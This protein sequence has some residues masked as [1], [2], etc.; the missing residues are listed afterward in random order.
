[1]ITRM[2]FG[3]ELGANS[4]IVQSMEGKDTCHD[5]LNGSGSIDID[6]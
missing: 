6:D 1:M 2:F 4:V 3:F 5:E